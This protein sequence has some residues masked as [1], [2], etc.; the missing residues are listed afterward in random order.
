M[1]TLI[2]GAN[3]SI[4]PHPSFSDSNILSPS[5]PTPANEPYVP[6]KMEKMQPLAQVTGTPAVT[7]PLPG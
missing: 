2:P 4:I 7:G 5:C 1:K 6:P 3:V